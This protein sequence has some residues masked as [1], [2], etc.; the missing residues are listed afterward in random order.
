MWLELVLQGSIT[1]EETHSLF[2]DFQKKVPTVVCVRFAV[3]FSSS[4]MMSVSNI[5]PAETPN[6][7]YKPSSIYK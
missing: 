1:T 6:L 2:Q 7:Y 5:V 4:W 3:A